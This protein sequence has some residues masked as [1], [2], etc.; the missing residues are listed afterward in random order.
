MSDTVTKK[1]VVDGL[2]II[3]LGLSIA[4]LG[5]LGAAMNGDAAALAASEAYADAIEGIDAFLGDLEAA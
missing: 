3:K 1:S 2:G 5:Y 4:G